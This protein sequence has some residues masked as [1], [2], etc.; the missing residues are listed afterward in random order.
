[1]KA[2]HVFIERGQ[3]EFHL[4]TFY[5]ILKFSKTFKACLFM[6]LGIKLKEKSITLNFIRTIV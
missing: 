3:R 1:M 2:P 6:S 4:Y 5:P